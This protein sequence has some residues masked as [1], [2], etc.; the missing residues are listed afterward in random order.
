M[1]PRHP[2]LTICMAL[3]AL[4]T[5]SADRPVT[6]VN[7]ALDRPNILFIA[8]DDLRPELGCYG[9]RQVKS[10]NLDRFASR[11][12]V[13]NR[14]YCQVPVCGPSRA[15]LLTGVRPTRENCTMWNAQQLAPDVPTLP[16]WFRKAGYHTISNGKIFHSPLDSRDKS[17]S[18]EPTLDFLEQHDRC[19]RP[20]LQQ[21]ANEQRKVGPFYEAENVPDAGYVDGR[22]CDKTISDL[23]RLKA[24][25]KPFFLGCGFIRP[26]LP[27]FAPKKYWDLYDR[28]QIRIAD[29]R[30]RP[31]NAPEE[32]L[33]SIEMQRYTMRGHEYNSDD[34]HRVARHGYYASVSYVDALVGRLLAALE[35]LD[36]AENTIVIIWGDHGWH[37]GEHNFWSKHNLLHQAIRAPLMISVPGMQTSVRLDALVEF[38]DIYP[39]L[40]AMARLP[41][42][43]HLDGSNLLPLILQPDR[44]WK[45]AVY[46]RFRKGST[47]I[48]H[49]YIYTEYDQGRMLYDLEGDPQ[50]NVNLLTR[51]EY[52]PVATMMHELLRTH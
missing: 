2:L 34:F 22:I 26:H 33:G 1:I 13:F 30:Y 10:P 20:E 8:I 48:T 41:A 31:L 52:Q 4:V 36:L 23:K 19:L 16:E 35:E 38:L 43:P 37:L 45:D 29:N 6:N 49:R 28:N 44:K 15:S 21:E 47:V 27:F 5:F 18:E 51:L 12:V 17:W 42:P 9:A 40:C 50:E 24:M 14:A 32:L 25:G 39:T 7:A 3:C 11:A 46:A